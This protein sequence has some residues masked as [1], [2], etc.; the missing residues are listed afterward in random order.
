MKIR[1]KNQRGEDALVDRAE[2]AVAQMTEVVRDGKE[3]IRRLHRIMA[4]I[5]RLESAKP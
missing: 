1:D 4:K 2:A 3:Q 5:D